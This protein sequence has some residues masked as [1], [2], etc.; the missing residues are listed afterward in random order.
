M[1]DLHQLRV[2]THEFFKR[3]WYMGTEKDYP[4]WSIEWKFEGEVPDNMYNGCYAWLKDGE[5]V[6]IG[7]AMNKGMKGYEGHSLGTRISKYWRV[8]KES[9]IKGVYRPSDDEADKLDS[10]VTLAF[11]GKGSDGSLNQDY[12]A[13]ALEL[14]LIRVIKPKHNSRG[15]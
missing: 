12:L 1:A 7:I 15:K 11:K 3:H 6:Y 14:Y 5:V 2:L 13:C 4:T 8:N 9:R 10:I